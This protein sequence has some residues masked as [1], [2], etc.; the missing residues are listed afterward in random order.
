MISF[1]LDFFSFLLLLLKI[2]FFFF[3]PIIH[4]SESSI[5]SPLLPHYYT[6]VPSNYLY[7]YYYYYYSTILFCTFIINSI[8]TTFATLFFPLFLFYNNNK[9]LL[10]I[11]IFIEYITLFLLKYLILPLT[12]NQSI[13]IFFYSMLTNG[14][15]KTIFRHLVI[16]NYSL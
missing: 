8:N 11:N 4:F 13:N 7:Y 16:N 1:S 14:L 12:Q 10:Y 15:K 6:S 5:F 3:V 2:T 9:P